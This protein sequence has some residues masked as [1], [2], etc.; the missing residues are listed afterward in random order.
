ML[1][2]L[3]LVLSS[4]TLITLQNLLKKKVNYHLIENGLKL[5]LAA[6][7]V[8][9]FCLLLDFLI[10]YIHLLLVLSCDC[11]SFIIRLRFRLL[12]SNRVAEGWFHNE[13]TVQAKIPSK[14][15]LRKDVWS[16]KVAFII[17]LRFRPKF[18]LNGLYEK[19]FR[20][21]RLVL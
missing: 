18:Q 13:I 9:I 6:I 21:G 8:F 15:T 1:N 12:D 4:Y 20:C 3:L 10:Q 14:W 16:Q 17:T 11:F 5:T 19:L 7:N 2:T